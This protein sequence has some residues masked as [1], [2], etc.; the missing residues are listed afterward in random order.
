MHTN[1]A[2]NPLY[3]AGLIFLLMPFPLAATP[4]CAELNVVI[5][6]STK[7]QGQAIRNADQLFAA[8]KGAR[9]GE[10]FL[11]APGNY[12]VLSLKG[13]FRAPVTLR[14]ADVRAMASFSEAYIDHASNITFDTIKFDYIFSPGESYHSSKFRVENS[15]DI[16]FINSLFD[17]DMA[18][19]TGTAADGLGTGKGLIVRGSKNIN[20]VNSEFHSW[21]TG[22]II[23]TSSDI[24]VTGNNI[25]GIRSDGIKL[26]RIDRAL[27]EQ[28]YIHDF[29]GAASLSDH[30]DMIQIQR[31]SGTGVSELTIRDNVFDMASGDWT[32][33]IWAGRDRASMD[34]PT[35]WHRNVLIENNI[36]Y[37]A[38]THGISIDLANGLSVRRNSLIRVRRLNTKNISIPKIRISKNSRYVVIEQNIAGAIGGYEGQKSWVVVNN[39]LIQDT[40]PSATGFYDRQFIYSATSPINGYN[41]Y[42]VR[43]GSNVDRFN[44]GA[45]LPRNF[46]P[47]R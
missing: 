18:S 3:L 11:L 9:G 14:S 28:N 13:T 32:Q 47:C 26:G 36:I 5:T 2:F 19:G 6:S 24:H 35:N 16:T 33:T 20:V 44:A 41:E 45:T 46:P 17:G 42:S 38:H 29:K 15:S 22:L 34:D 4:T 27:V 39:V 23:N 7:L 10:T 21:W 43:P 37:N 1:G 40:S 25:H 30:R 8:L 31:S 12:G